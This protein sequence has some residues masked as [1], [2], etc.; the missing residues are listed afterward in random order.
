MNDLTSNES[1]SKAKIVY[2]DQKC[3]ISLAKIYY[4]APINRDRELLDK[5]IESSDK[6]TAIF[7][8][9]LIHCSETCSISKP[10][11]RKQLASLMAKISKCYTL[12]PHW[13][14]IMELEIKNIILE[15]LNLPL[16][17]I[18]DYYVG[19]GITR[20]IGEKPEIIS[21]N[22]DFSQQLLEELNREIL[23][24]LTKPE[25]LELLLLQKY[26]EPHKQEQL[27]AVEEFEIIRKKL[28]IIKDNDLRRR[29]FLVQNFKATIF[30]KI[31]R[32]LYE[33]HL[34][35]EFLDNFF[36]NFDIEEFLDRLPTA[37]CEFT[38]LFQRDQ[39]LQRPIKVNDI[40]DIWYLTLAIPYSDIV[41]T[42]RMWASILRQAKLDKKCNTIILSSIE[43][44]S[45]Y[46]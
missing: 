14:P 43:E 39:Q 45:D 34:P 26:N 28:K 5:I 20:L 6:G 7:P 4:G 23:D 11:W 10:R 33:W 32:I 31:V 29:A 35:K 1:T 17:N 15:K 46:L 36:K 25:T 2:L 12:L 38:L 37:L 8:I 27:K 19:R 44:L 22:K 24:A 9:S 42:E 40:N 41:V 30:P 18:R 21:N 3:W 13:M 16:F